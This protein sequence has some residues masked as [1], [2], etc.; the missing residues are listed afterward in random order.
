MARSP[1]VPVAKSAHVTGCDGRG[2]GQ[3]RSAAS[4]IA[5]VL[6]VSTLS[7][8]AA[9]TEFVVPSGPIITLQDGREIDG[10]VVGMDQANLVIR[11]VDG[12]EESVLRSTVDNVAFE[13]VAG[14][15]LI[16]ELVGWTDG[17]YQ[18]AT[19]EAALK[20]YSMAPASLE[21]APEDLAPSVAAIEPEVSEDFSTLEPGDAAS[22][23]GGD[24][25]EGTSEESGAALAVAATANDQ[26]DTASEAVAETAIEGGDNQGVIESEDAA[27]SPD[28]ALSITV[29]VENSGENGPPVIFNVELSR[30]SESSVVLIYATID[31]TAVDGEDYEANRGV[32]VMKPGEQTARIETLIIDDTESEG[33][34]DLKLFLTV[35]PTVA[36]VENREIIATIDDDD[37]G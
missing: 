36:V 23:G 33:Q 16:G 15:Q 31:G 14:R 10:H 6:M 9:S 4:A 2:A 5:A 11:K 8:Y 25:T 24:V 26:V 12:T 30:P 37:Q 18:I 34:E 1:V 29:S 21:T 19:T 28:S 7:A 13:T 20:I 17:I 32:L 27:V 22:A 3:R 35:D